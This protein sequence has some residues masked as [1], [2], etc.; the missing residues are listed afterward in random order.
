MVEFTINIK[1]CQ[2]AHPLVMTFIKWFK[3][4][5]WY[6][7]S[8]LT[9]Y[10]L[11]KDQYGSGQ[12]LAKHDEEQPRMKVLQKMMMVVMFDD[13]YQLVILGFYFTRVTSWYH[14]RI[15]LHFFLKKNIKKVSR[16]LFAFCE[17]SLTKIFVKWH[18]RGS[19]R[20]VSNVSY[21]FN[22]QD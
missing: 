3:T 5:T 13:K 14:Y 17:K 8:L 12:S 7:P 9:E 10:N 15:L 22:H 11:R 21:T 20:R 4:L 16:F 1:N 18:R 6:C 2:L 19:M